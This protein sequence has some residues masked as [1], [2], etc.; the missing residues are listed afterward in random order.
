MWTK[1]HWVDGPWPGKLAVSSRPRGGDWLSDELS[2]WKSE[3]LEAVLSL[4]TSLEEK[5]LD[6]VQEEHQT[7]AAGM[8]FLSLP[9]P[10]RQVPGSETELT[11]ILE[12]MDSI[13]SA[14]KNLVVHCRQGIGRTGLV[15]ACL[16]ITKGITP[17]VAIKRV[18]AARG[19][20]VPETIEQRDWID[21]YATVMTGAKLA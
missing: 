1:L 2:G 11:A 13:L 6:L 19:L 4:L 10:D 18:S 5:D 14:G 15:A 3:G 8:K 21:H 20:E 9:I 7:H 16:L 12:Q 17:D